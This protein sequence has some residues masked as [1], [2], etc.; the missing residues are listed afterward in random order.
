MKLSRPNEGPLRLLKIFCFGVGIPLIGCIPFLNPWTDK[1]VYEGV[2]TAIGLIGAVSLCFIF[3][4]DRFSSEVLELENS[5]GVWIRFSM[6]AFAA[7]ISFHAVIPDANISIWCH[8]LA[9]FLAGL[10]LLLVWLPLESKTLSSVLPPIAFFST[11]LICLIYTL[12]PSLIPNTATNNGVHFPA[13]VL[14]LWGALGFVGATIRFSKLANRYR[15]PRD[16][17]LASLSLFMTTSILFFVIAERWSFS[18]WWLHSLQSLLFIGLAY[19]AFRRFARTYEWLNSLGEKN[20]A[21]HRHMKAKVHEVTSGQ[22]DVAHL[23]ESAGIGRWRWRVSGRTIYLDQQMKTLFNYEGE[24]PIP[25]QRFLNLMVE[26]DRFR[27]GKLM[28]RA[29]NGEETIDTEFKIQCDDDSYRVLKCKLDRIEGNDQLSTV[30]TAICWDISELKLT[31]EQITEE[32]QRSLF[33]AKMATM[34]HLAV[35]IARD[36][37]NQLAIV[38]INAQAIRNIT[39]KEKMNR[40]EIKQYSIKILSKCKKMAVLSQRLQMFESA[41]ESEPFSIIPIQELIAEVLSFCTTSLKRD[42]IELREPMSES[43]IMA[44]VQVV[45]IQ[46]VLLNLLNNAI[47]AVK[48]TESPWVEIGVEEREGAIRILVSNSGTI[49]N[50]IRNKIM[51]PFFTTK[52]VGKARGLGLS[53]SQDILTAHGGKI[54]LSD[55]QNHTQFVITLPKEHTAFAAKKVS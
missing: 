30:V 50:E 53:I 44:E 13:V 3:I 5:N 32:R 20:S 52:P 54:Y 2:L 46:Q 48:G 43:V 19:L 33:S 16:A 12:F 55:L 22:R 18:W 27:I 11:F 26:E 37:A 34:G 41:E 42:D 14:H 29:A 40:T 31:L 45:Q 7:A 24:S 17:I 47:D 15:H 8:S 21:L 4:L 23:Q 38:Q 39:V 25:H 35:G 49:P 6:L 36:I 1:I 9:S 10:S 51:E 28:M